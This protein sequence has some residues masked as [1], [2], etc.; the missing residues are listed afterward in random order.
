MIS[1]KR[2]YHLMMLVGYEEGYE[3][4]SSHL[5]SHHCFSATTRTEMTEKQ[6]SHSTYLSAVWPVT[7]FPPQH[8]INSHTWEQ[9]IMK[10][11]IKCYN[12]GYSKASVALQASNF[13]RRIFSKI[14]SQSV[15]CEMYNL[16]LDQHLHLS[17]CASDLWFV[18]HS[19]NSG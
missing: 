16:W 10:W 13:L 6:C 3:G 8:Q 14:A 11:I 12:G 18:K 1:L 4:E 5:Q 9:S 7:T 19:I 17:F 2:K 15:S